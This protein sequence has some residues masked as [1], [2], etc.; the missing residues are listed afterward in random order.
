MRRLH[1]APGISDGLVQLGLAHHRAGRHEMARMLIEE[2]IT[3][4]GRLNDLNGVAA[5]RVLLGRVLAAIGALDDGETLL[6]TAADAAEHLGL[7]GIAVEA[8][9][10]LAEVAMRR[11]L[12]AEAL[13]LL[14]RQGRIAGSRLDRVARAAGDL[15][16][17]E[18]A[19]R[20]GAADARALAGRMLWTARASRSTELAAEARRLAASAR[21][22][23]A[24]LASLRAAQ[25]TA[26]RC[27]FREVAWRVRLD[28]GLRLLAQGDGE[29]A[30][31][32][33]KEGMKLVRAL[34]DELPVRRRDT[35]LADPRKQALRAAFAQAIDRVG[36]PAA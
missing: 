23:P 24:G 4:R 33:L 1:D 34:H 20:S 16:R 5:A 11:D 2:V 3:R 31:R 36:A 7:D 18:I 35:Y 26:D 28:L 13:S 21:P 27:G 9:R 30:L 17:A 14:D 6:R 19:C 22:G 32:V 8:L 12:P 10:G 25:R 29:E 15:V